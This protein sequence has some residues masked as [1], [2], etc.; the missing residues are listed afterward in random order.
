MIWLRRTVSSFLSGVRKMTCPM[1]D[2]LFRLAAAEQPEYP[3]IGADF[4][5]AIGLVSG[6]ADGMVTER[7]N[8]IRKLSSSFHQAVVFHSTSRQAFTGPA[9]YG[10]D[11]GECWGGCN[12]CRSWPRCCLAAPIWSA[13]PTRQE[14]LTGSFSSP[15]VPFR[16]ARPTRREEFFPASSLLQPVE[17]LRR[18]A[19]RQPPGEPGA[20]NP[21]ALR[22]RPS[23]PARPPGPRHVR[24]HVLK[25]SGGT[26]RRLHRARVHGRQL[27]PT[28]QDQY[29]KPLRRERQTPRPAPRKSL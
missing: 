5:T 25:L 10:P 3:S 7:C 18:Y 9:N 14:T 20:L 21:V 27:T 6:S 17:L 1:L 15:R 26:Q 11:P 13:S 29:T 12:Q 8:T 24:Q 23:E 2:D 19:A 22:Y 28:T 16:S 4:T